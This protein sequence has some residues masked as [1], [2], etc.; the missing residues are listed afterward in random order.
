MDHLQSTFDALIAELRS[1]ASS[2]TDFAQRVALV[3]ADLSDRAAVDF[4]RSPGALIRDL[5]RL[6]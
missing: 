1:D 4:G 2:D 6:V 3:C 5:F